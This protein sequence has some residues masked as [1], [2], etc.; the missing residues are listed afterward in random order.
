MKDTVY[1]VFNQRSV[2]RM[3][4]QRLP[5]LKGGEVA[6]KLTIKV[7]DSNFRTPL[8]TAEIEVGEDQ[9]ITNPEAE[10]EVETWGEQDRNE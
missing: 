1:L 10:V 4:K 8:A 7:D 5:N 2:Q 6:I 9:I 3:T